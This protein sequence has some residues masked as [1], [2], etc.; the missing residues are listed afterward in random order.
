MSKLPQLYFTDIFDILIVAY[1]IYKTFRLVKETRAEQLIKGIVILLVLL[2]LS[3]TLRLNAINFIIRN[4]MQFG[5]IA[6]LIV[7]QPELRRA[8]E[9][10]GRSRFSKFFVFDDSIEREAL[11]NIIKQISDACE[12]L[13][14]D[15]IG[16][17]IVI[18]RET[19]I[20]DIIRTGINLDSYISSELLLNIFTPN[21]P[22]HD[23]AVVIREN[24]IKAAGCFLPLTQ[25]QYLSKE[26]GT[27]HRAAIGISENSDAAVVVVSEETGKISI[28]LDGD[29]TRNLTI[30]TLKK[31][32]HKVLEKPKNNNNGML[33]RK[34]KKE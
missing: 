19:K 25:N 23:G 32:L 17:L 30:E 29:L 27:R 26:L 1:I 12:V 28:A 10:M 5:V 4:A 20:G 18:E 7:F 11:E 21:A 14:K 34:E 3:Y 33:K 22:L 31:A 2:Q 13:S 16:A 24:R 8:L 6:I 15:K 9:K